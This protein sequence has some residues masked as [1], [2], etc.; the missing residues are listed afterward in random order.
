VANDGDDV[1]D[2]GSEFEMR[3]AATGNAAYGITGAI[4]D[5]D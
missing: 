4:V 3:T 2:Y 5:A 1:T